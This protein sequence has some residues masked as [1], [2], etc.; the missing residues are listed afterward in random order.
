MPDFVTHLCTV[1]LARRGLFDRRFPLFALGAVL[2]DL[3]SRPVH[4]LFPAAY[5]F[6]RPLHS[7]VVCVLYCVLLALLFV[8]AS[9]RAAFACLLAG[10]GLHLMF[11]ALQKQTGPEYLWLFP[12]S[13]RPGCVGL[14][15]PEQALFLLPVT[16]GATAAV[17]AWRR[18][19]G[20]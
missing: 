15:W 17:T 9:R 3:L 7:P 4:I 6:V 11:D 18:R 20:S 14:F 5:P 13:W 10:T 16:L 19:G 8:P 2:P 1:Q 12:F